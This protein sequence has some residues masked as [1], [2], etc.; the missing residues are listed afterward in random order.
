MLCNYCVLIAHIS[1][2]LVWLSILR[3]G[4]I[5]RER[6][7]AIKYNTNK[8]KVHI[9]I[10]LIIIQTNKQKKHTK[11]IGHKHEDGRSEG[12]ARRTKS[13][14]LGCVYWSPPLC[15]RR[16]VRTAN[17]SVMRKVRGASTTGCG[18]ETQIEDLSPVIWSKKRNKKQNEE[19]KKSS[20]S[21]GKHTKSR[22]TL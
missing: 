9:M 1:L 19:K 21:R 4:S 7:S 15:T 6:P 10:H 2:H 20:V 8:G 14:G 22:R 3:L 18:C 16:R 12:S 13:C 5:P 11:M 17:V